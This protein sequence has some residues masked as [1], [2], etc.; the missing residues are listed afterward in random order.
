MF[1][2]CDSCVFCRADNSLWGI[3]SAVRPSLY[4]LANKSNK[5]HNSVSYIYFSFL[6]VSGIHVPI[7]R[8]K[9]LFPCVTGT[10]PIVWVA[11][12]LLVSTHSVWQVP[13]THGYSNSVQ[14][15]YLFLFS[16]CFGHPCAHHTEKLL[17]PCVTGTCHTVCVA[18]GDQT[19]PVDCDKYQWHMFTVIFSGWWAYGCPKHVERRNKWIH[20]TELCT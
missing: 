12:V 4:N 2:S 18:S 6:H 19:P 1:V 5:V 3:S 16:T 8:R 14:Y 20:W 10:C 17:Y 15:I 13:V 9:L 7:I 11:S